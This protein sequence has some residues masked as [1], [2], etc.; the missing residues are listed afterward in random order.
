MFNRFKGAAGGSE[1]DRKTDGRGYSVP[2]RTQ[3]SGPAFAVI[4]AESEL[5]DRLA[6]FYGAS[7][8]VAIDAYDGRTLVLS[9]EKDVCVQ[10]EGSTSFVDSGGNTAVQIDPAMG[11]VGLYQYRK[12]HPTQDEVPEGAGVVYL[13]ELSSRGTRVDRRRP[14]RIALFVALHHPSGEF[15][16]RQLSS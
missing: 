12:A 4:S 15:H 5:Q 8:Y 14:D 9:S 6:A 11:T 7:D 3:D 16:V 1:D 10:S 2:E 13:Y